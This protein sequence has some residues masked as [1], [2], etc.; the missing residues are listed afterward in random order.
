M[1]PDVGNVGG[2]SEMRNVAMTANGLGVQVNPHVWGSAVMIAAT[3]HV[4]STI[5]PCPPARVPQPYMQEPVMEF[6]RTPSVIRNELCT[7]VF[8]QK[9]SFVDVPMGPGLGVDVNESVL[10]RLS[11]RSNRVGQD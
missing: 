4:A 9:D 8:D 11:V 2:I 6:D 10:Q 5:P 7:V 3:L 1:Q